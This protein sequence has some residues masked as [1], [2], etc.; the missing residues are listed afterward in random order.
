MCRFCGAREDNSTCNWVCYTYTD[1]KYGTD[2]TIYMRI[3]ILKVQCDLCER[4]YH[5]K[6]IEKHL[7]EKL[8][9]EI[10]ELAFTGPCC[11]KDGYIYI[12]S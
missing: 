4:W 6:C 3:C 5:Q 10:I 8:K 2:V 12:A 11:S 9:D 1:I 7:K